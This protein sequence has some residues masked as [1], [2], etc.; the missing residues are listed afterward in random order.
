VIVLDDASGSDTW[1][2][3]IGLRQIVA[4]VPV[5]IPADGFKAALAG[6]HEEVNARTALLGNAAAPAHGATMP[7]RGAAA[8]PSGPRRFPWIPASIITVVLIAFL[9]AYILIRH[10]DAGVNPGP[11]ASSV[12]AQPPAIKMPAESEEKVDLL[13]EKAQ[14]A[15]VDRRFIDPP[16]SSALALY[17]RALAL[18]PDN[19]EAHQGLQRLVEIL[20]TRVQSALDERKIDVALQSLET[21]RSLNPSDARL[22]ALD[23]RIASLRAEFG[24]AQILAAI[25]AQNFDRAAQLIDDAA[26][27]KTLANAKLAQLREELRR[28]REEFD[29]ANILKLIDSRLQ[30]DKLVEPRNDSAAYYLSQARAAGA[31]AAA[32]QAPAQEIYRRLVQAAR[33]AIDQRH[34][35][36]ADRWIADLHM[37]GAAPSA[38]AGLQRDLNAARSQQTSAAPEQPQYLELAQS[39]LAQGKLTEPDNDSALYYVNQLRA[40]DPKNSGLPRISGAVQSQILDQARSALDTGQAARA[41]VLLQLASGLGATA[42]LTGLNQRLAQAKQAGAGMPVVAEASLT[43]VKGVQIDYPAEALRKNI[44]GWVDLSYVV[45]TDGKITTINVLDSN[46]NGVFDAAATRAVSRARYKPMTQDGKPIAV[47]TKLRIAFRLSK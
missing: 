21:A 7:A 32:L 14:Q 9:A 10:D 1:T 24:P 43:R 3:P 20:F 12:P 17:K 28:R 31:N 27:S 2:N 36:E 42:E 26:R 23:E 8:T 16:D 18:D 37:Y 29:I 11:I 6:A 15:M 5:P 44:E 22:A 25:N 40:V 4:H 46:P 19:G 38:F 33:A 13:I 45:T 47:S 41:E 39:R 30:Q 34:F 35:S